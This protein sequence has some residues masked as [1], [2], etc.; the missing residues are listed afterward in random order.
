MATRPASTG[1]GSATARP[2][3]DDPLVAPFAV[4]IELWWG[5]KDVGAALIEDN[6]L[7]LHDRVENLTAAIPKHP[8]PDAA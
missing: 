5:E 1:R 6:L 7:V 3:V 8:G 2:G 4:T